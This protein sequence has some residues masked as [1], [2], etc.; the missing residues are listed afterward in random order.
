MRQLAWVLVAAVLQRKIPV[1][2]L[3]KCA[4]ASLLHSGFKNQVLAVL[5]IDWGISFLLAIKTINVYYHEFLKVRKHHRYVILAHIFSW[6]ILKLS[7]SFTVSLRL[8]WLAS[9]FTPMAVGMADG[10]R[11]CHMG[12]SIAVCY[13]AAGSPVS[14]ARSPKMETASL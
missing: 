1:F 6:E 13:M 7:T 11:L 9:K 5:V 8:Y 12:L 3:Q 2:Y 10:Q 4:I 14:E